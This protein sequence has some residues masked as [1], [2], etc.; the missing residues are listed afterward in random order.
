M[1][2]MNERRQ[3]T[4]TSAMN[5]VVPYEQKIGALTVTDMRQQVQ[6]IQQV[7]REVMIN[8]VHY[9]VIPGTE[10]PSLYKA[11]AEKLNLTF[12]LDPQYESIERYEG[13]H[14]HVKSKC[15]LGH[16]PSGQGFSSG[17]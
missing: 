16:I 9:G 14:L 4:R 2:S 1:R 7:M 3:T 12:R 17:E 6:L 8:G 10:K 5:E 11:G 15:T 13:L